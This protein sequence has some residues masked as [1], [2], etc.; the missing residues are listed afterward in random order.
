MWRSTL[1]ARTTLTDLSEFLV[2]PLDLE[3]ATIS[4]AADDGTPQ[5]RV[6]S[7]ANDAEKFFAGVIF[8]RVAAQLDPPAW[9]VKKLDPLYKPDP[10]EI[11][12]Q[13][14]SVLAPVAYAIDKLDNLSTVGPFDG[15]DEAYK[16]R[17]SYWAAVLTG[18]D[19]RKAY[20]FRSFTAAAELKRKRGAALVSRQGTFN[21]VKESIFVFD[22]QIDCFVFGDYVYVIR[23]RD[24]RRIFDQLNA[25]LRRAKRAARDLHAKVPIANFGDFEQA[26]A[27][28]SRLADKILAVRQR[29]YFDQ[30]GYAMLEPVIAEFSLNIPTTEVDGE[31]QFVFR[32]EPDQRFRILKLVDDDYLRSSMTNHRYEVNSKTDPPTP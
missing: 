23:K 28:D 21:V 7:L 31:T 8:K 20:F 30:L 11:E 5:L 10:E 14:V 26:C 12:W 6:L 19:G 27:T 1:T 22:D 17:L 15:S 24:F 32:T 2:G 25:V 3:V 16:R 4:R 13:H 29:D 9:S 18:A